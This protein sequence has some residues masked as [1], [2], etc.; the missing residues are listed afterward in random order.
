MVRSRPSEP[1]PLP[2]LDHI[3]NDGLPFGEARE[4]RSFE[5]GDM[6]EDVLATVESNEAV[7]PLG[8]EPLHCAGFLDGYARR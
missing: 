2:P 4:P 5:S 1:S 6:D 3:D 8:I 7:V